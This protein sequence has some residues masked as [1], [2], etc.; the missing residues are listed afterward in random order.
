MIRFGGLGESRSRR[1]HRGTSPSR[2]AV[3]RATLR[4]C[5][6]SA[7]SSGTP[8]PELCRPCLENARQ[9]ARLL[10]NVAGA[11]IDP[12]PGS[13]AIAIVKEQAG[14]VAD[15]KDLKS[16]REAYARMSAC[17]DFPLRNHLRLKP[18]PTIAQWPRKIGYKKKPR[19]KI[20]ILEKK[21]R[22]AA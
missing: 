3:R 7:P 21:W 18:I 15:A 10:Q 4:A 17:L 9:A 13:K 14:V 19:Y 16:A 12:T 5:H 22:G 20:H 1:L 6:E 11:A 2:I 8:S